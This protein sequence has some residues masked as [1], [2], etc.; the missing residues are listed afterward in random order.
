MSGLR[1][2]GM[3]L[4][5]L[6]G[7][8]SA[9]LGGGII[10]VTA[11]YGG[12]IGEGLSAGLGVVE[13]AESA[14]RIVGEEISSTSGLLG[15]VSATVAT[16]GEAIRQLGATLEAVRHAL[17]EV[18]GASRQASSSIDQLSGPLS[19]L[20]PASGLR[21]LSDRLE[22]SAD[23]TDEVRQELDSLELIMQNASLVIDGVEASVDSFAL[24]VEGTSETFHRAADRLAEGR[25]LA[26]GAVAS[27]LLQ[28]LSFGIGG[29]LLLQGLVMLFL[30]TG[31]PRQPKGEA[32]S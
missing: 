16:T 17:E 9:L 14:V 21:T 11:M 8:V 19:A 28:W 1:G 23:A 4:A 31:G 15:E 26:S 27:G 12:E 7:L 25:N 32:R 5:V 2:I 22:S 30:G 20:A 24:S 10:V 18:A 3:A 29:F 6:L 13:E